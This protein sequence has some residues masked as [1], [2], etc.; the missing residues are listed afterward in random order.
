[1]VLGR[2][3]HTAN[4]AWYWH[5]YISKIGAPSGMTKPQYKNLCREYDEIEKNPEP[6]GIGLSHYYFIP[7]WSDC[8]TWVNAYTT[9]SHPFFIPTLLHDLE[10][11]DDAV[12]N[13]MTRK[14]SNDKFKMR[15]HKM[16]KFALWASKLF[17][18]K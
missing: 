5:F 14:L 8:P 13:E 1:M 18:K 17:R 9:G 2:V 6:L 12:F 11:I 3:P 15:L 7:L 16:F 10:L 4:I